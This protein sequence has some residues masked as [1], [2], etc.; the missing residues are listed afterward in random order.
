MIQVN[1]LDKCYGRQVIFEKA[2]F[3]LDPGE[4]VGLVG[5]NGHGKTTEFEEEL[6]DLLTVR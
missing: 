4:R 3:T 2:G 5:R 6:E 1:S